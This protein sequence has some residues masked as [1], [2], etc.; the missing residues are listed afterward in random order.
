MR[1]NNDDILIS[2]SNFYSEK[3]VLAELDLSEL[4]AEFSDLRELE[5]KLTGARVKS[6]V[7]DG[8]RSISFKLSPNQSVILTM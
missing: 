1:W 7:K 8:K 5:D 4:P 2:V 3:E 6:E